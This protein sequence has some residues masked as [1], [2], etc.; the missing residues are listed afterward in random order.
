MHYSTLPECM[1]LY[2]KNIL[3]CFSKQLSNGRQKVKHLKFIRSW[4]PAMLNT[5]S[6][7]CLQSPFYGALF[8]YTLH[9]VFR[10]TTP[11]L[12]ETVYLWKWVLQS[13][14]QSD[15]YPIL[16][17]TTRQ[18]NKNSIHMGNKTTAFH[19]TTSN[20]RFCRSW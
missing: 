11:A 10:T 14:L 6:S 7:D 12:T 17:V 2:T 13:K 3:P 4:I 9:F 1:M 5:C 15:S 18:M 19:C 20:V 8:W 16:W